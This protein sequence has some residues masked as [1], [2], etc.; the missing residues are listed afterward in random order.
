M[1]VAVEGL[2][3]ER[4]TCAEHEL[5]KHQKSTDLALLLANCLPSSLHAAATRT[6]VLPSPVEQLAS[7]HVT[8]TEPTVL[9]S[10]VEQFWSHPHHVTEIEST[11]LSSPILGAVQVATEV[12]TVADETVAVEMAAVMVILTM[13]MLPTPP[14]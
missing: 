10:P 13:T 2:G 9:L 4:G 8:E 14:Q 5:S 1:A 12:E 7:P 11:V 6:F 3:T